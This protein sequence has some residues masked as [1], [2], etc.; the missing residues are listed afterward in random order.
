MKRL[1]TAPDDE[2]LVSW[3]RGCKRMLPL[4]EACSL[5]WAFELIR[6]YGGKVIV[7][8]HG[9]L[10]RLQHTLCRSCLMR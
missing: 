6:S 9:N 8:H 3:L 2:G 1:A 7:H 4:G 5:F 10:E